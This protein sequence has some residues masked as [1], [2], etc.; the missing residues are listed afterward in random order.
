MKNIKENPLG[1]A[2]SREYKFPQEVLKE[3]FRFG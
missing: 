2:A 3:D 1:K